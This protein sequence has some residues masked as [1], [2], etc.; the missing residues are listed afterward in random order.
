MAVQRQVGSMTDC[1]PS[2]VD[3]RGK[4]F[5]LC[6]RIAGP[7]VDLSGLG[8]KVA[9]VISE[10]KDAGYSSTFNTGRQLKAIAGAAIAVGDKLSSDAAS[11][12][13][14]AAA[15]HYVFATAIS[16]AAN[17]EMV[18]FEMDQEGVLA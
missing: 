13:R 14:V 18:E 5:L 7:K 17:G 3:L 6:K 16:A 11:K 10:G 4:E 8:E 1:L 12:V 15:G 2:N 9:G